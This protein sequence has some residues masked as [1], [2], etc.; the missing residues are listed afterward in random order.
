MTG[1]ITVNNIATC[2]GWAKIKEDDHYPVTVH[3]I[4]DDAVVSSTVAAGA[5]R[6]DEEEHADCWFEFPLSDLPA[7]DRAGSFVV[8]GETGEMLGK[9]QEANGSGKAHQPKLGDQEIATY[10]D[11]LASGLTPEDVIGAFYLDVLKRPVDGAGLGHLLSEIRSGAIS[12]DQVRRNLF[13][14]EEYGRHRRRLSDAPG[15]LFARKIIYHT[16]ARTLAFELLLGSFLRKDGSLDAKLLRF[17]PALAILP[18]A[19]ADLA[20]DVAVGLSEREIFFRALSHLSGRPSLLLDPAVLSGQD[21]R[22]A[23]DDFTQIDGRTCL[24]PCRSRLF[25]SGWQEIEFGASGEFRWMMQIGVLYNPRPGS[26]VEKIEVS[27]DACYADLAGVL[28]FSEHQALRCRIQEKAGGGF[29][30]SITSDGGLF[31]MS[32][33]V[34][35]SRHASCPLRFN[36]TP[37]PRLI[38]ISLRDAR[39]VTSETAA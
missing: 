8:V 38:S 1:A 27:V 28:A 29:A 13:Q 35:I 33:L 9:G 12:Y 18:N 36:G 5:S 21:M 30:L 20:R 15:R 37:D 26:S 34:L 32:Y 2:R 10:R 11:A 22:V 23:Q 25:A 31:R 16:C 7:R 3:L 19:A 14:S 24:V 4:C 39:F 6:G 17:F